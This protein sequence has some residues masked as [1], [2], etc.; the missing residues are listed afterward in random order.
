MDSAHE[1]SNPTSWALAM[2]ANGLIHVLW[3][4][5]QAWNSGGNDNYLKYT[6]VDTSTGLWGTVEDIETAMGL[7]ENG[8][9]DELCAMAVDADGIPHIV[10]GL[11]DGNGVRRVAYRNRI[12]GSWSASSYVDD[13]SFQAGQYCQH[14]SICFDDAGRLVVGWVR[15]SGET[16]T[17]GR[18][19]IRVK[20]G[21]SWGTTHDIS[22]YNMWPGI[23]SGLR[24]YVDNAGRYH[25]AFLNTSKQIQYRFSDDQGASW[26]QNSP[27]SGTTEGDDPVVGPGPNGKARIYRH[28][29]RNPVGISYWEG[30]GG[31][32]SWGSS[33]EYTADGE[34]AFDCSVNI[35]WSRYFHYF[36]NLYDVAYW[37]SDYGGV[38]NQLRVGVAV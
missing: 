1:P 26:T 23:D 29:T 21:G 7:W 14:P 34:G 20:S 19:F 35:R 25:T 28:D 16:S 30:D 9:G 6:T 37:L 11:E 38:T 4:V 31:S 15:G 24:I 33:I 10:Y 5:R 17:D 36:S 12:G 27:G 8:Q 3:D 13:Q 22:G 2:G 18:P 32:A